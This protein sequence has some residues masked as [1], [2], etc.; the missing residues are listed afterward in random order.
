MHKSYKNNRR[1]TDA[2]EQY[3][4]I[5]YVAQRCPL[6]LS[7]SLSLSFFEIL[8]F[9]IFGRLGMK[10]CNIRFSVT[11]TVI[12]CSKQIKETK[13]I[14]GENSKQLQKKQE[15]TMDNRKIVERRNTD[16][17]SIRYR[18]RSRPIYF[19]AVRSLFDHRSSFGHIHGRKH[20]AC[21]I[22]LRLCSCFPVCQPYQY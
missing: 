8:I 2:T 22:N 1:R 12:A 13:C 17:A 15:T 9:V 3:F 10:D 6:S 16:E 7:L 20:Y 19:P 14:C 4:C 5:S 18:C 11:V 21:C